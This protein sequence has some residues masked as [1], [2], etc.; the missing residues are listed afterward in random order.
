MDLSKITQK[1]RESKL[2][3]KFFNQ[4]FYFKK[5]KFFFDKLGALVESDE[6]IKKSTFVADGPKPQRETGEK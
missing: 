3:Q 5:E 6:L 4:V 1:S 2:V